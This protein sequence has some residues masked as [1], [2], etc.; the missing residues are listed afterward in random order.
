MASMSKIMI[1]GNVGRDAEL[2][3][4]PNG[5]AVCDFSVAVNRVQGSGESRKEE[6]DWYR[7]SVWGKQG[8]IAQQY[9]RKGTSIFVEGRFQPRKYTDKAGAIQTSFDVSC[10]N[11]VLLSGRPAGDSAMSTGGPAPTSPD[12]DPDEIPF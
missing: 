10:D 12:F 1:I 4:T 8:E 7:V 5:R 11:F 9:V 6:T 3:M 2:R